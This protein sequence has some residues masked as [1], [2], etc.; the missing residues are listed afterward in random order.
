MKTPYTELSAI[1]TEC[2]FNQDILNTI[3]IFYPR[4]KRFFDNNNEKYS[5]RNLFYEIKL[6]M[7]FIK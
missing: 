7:T 5:N 4:Q 3:F 1:Y 2:I 6:V